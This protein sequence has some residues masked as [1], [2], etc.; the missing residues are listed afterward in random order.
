[1]ESILDMY[2]LVTFGNVYCLETETLK[3]PKECVVSYSLTFIMRERSE[4]VD[5]SAKWGDA[6]FWVRC[7]VQ[8]RC[9]SLFRRNKR[10]VEL[11]SSR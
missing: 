11:L 3:T 5:R 6:L 9:N 8:H 7:V 10:T 2:K 1:M 4:A